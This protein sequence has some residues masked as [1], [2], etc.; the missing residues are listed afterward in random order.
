MVLYYDQHTGKGYHLNNSITFHVKPNKLF[1]KKEGFS[2]LK[3]LGRHSS[4]VFP[5]PFIS[6][7]T[8]FMSFPLPWKEEN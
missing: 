4:F 6:F 1:S 7:P 8:P 3:N 2:K 5:L